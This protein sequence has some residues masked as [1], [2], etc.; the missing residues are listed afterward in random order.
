MACPL[1]KPKRKIKQIVLQKDFLY[2]F[3]KFFS[4]KLRTLPKKFFLIP[5]IECWFSLP[6]QLSKLKLEI[7]NCP[8]SLKKFFILVR[9]SQQAN[10]S[11]PIPRQKK[12]RLSKKSSFL[13]KYCFLYLPKSEHF[14]KLIQKT[15][16]F[17]YF[18][19]P[20]NYIKLP[21]FNFNNQYLANSPKFSPLGHWMLTWRMIS[22]IFSILFLAIYILN[23]FSF[24]CQK[25][26]LRH[27][28]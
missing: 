17:S 28:K 1:S 11:S 19:L 26:N 9:A 6:S 21:P 27:C 3:K 10:S 20:K 16:I 7:K 24:L 22:I 5:H 8:N 25:Q 15:T 14:S 13:N 4:N 18:H 2:F 12:L 23:T